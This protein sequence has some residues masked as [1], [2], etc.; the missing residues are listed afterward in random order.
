MTDDIL[1]DIREIYA[2]AISALEKQVLIE[3]NK[4]KLLTEKDHDSIG[5]VL[6]HHLIVEKYMDVYLETELKMP[7][8]NVKECT[9]AQ[10]LDKLPNNGVLDIIRPGI[11]EL[12][13]VRNKFAHNI[14]TSLSK[15]NTSEIDKVVAYI[16]VSSAATK[17]E[18]I[19]N[20]S[21]LAC[22]F[23]TVMP[24][25][26]AKK[27]EAANVRVMKILEENSLNP[28]TLLIKNH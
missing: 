21:Y 18:R 23:L 26:L 12:N 24:P 20:F 22:T 10:K 13:Y 17:I 6:K 25:N 2:P 3:K 8:K 19:E 27:I 14:N 9:F 1:N 5:R 16:R 28:L 4:Y 11:S 15:I 7:K